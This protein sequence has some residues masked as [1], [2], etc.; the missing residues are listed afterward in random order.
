M[1]SDKNTT[2]YRQ[3]QQLN[4][5]RACFETFSATKGFWLDNQPFKAAT[6]QDFLRTYNVS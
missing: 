2:A 1:H 3:Q 6:F 5:S 4:S